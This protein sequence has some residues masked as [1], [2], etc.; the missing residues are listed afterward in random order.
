MTPDRGAATLIVVTSDKDEFAS[1]RRKAM[2]L[3][4]A[5]GQIMILYDWDAPTLFG[6]PLPTW[7][8]GEGS[9]SQFSRRLDQIQLRAAGRAAIADQVADAEALG[10]RAFGWL[11]SDHGPAALA[12]YAQEQGALTVVISAALEDLAGLDALLNG[13]RPAEALDAQT[14]ATVIVVEEA[15]VKPDT[16][17]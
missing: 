2:D 11:P 15:T 8:S 7:W 10:I 9:E 1:A 6:D 5:S 3:A 16:P 14:P 4:H 13:D 17:R 12:A